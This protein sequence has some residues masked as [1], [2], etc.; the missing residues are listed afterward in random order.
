[1]VFKTI[2]L[3]ISWWK[4]FDNYHDARYVREKKLCGALRCSVVSHFFCVVQQ[5]KSGLV[6][7]IF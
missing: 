7:L 4:N 1:M 6:R 2:Q 5:P 3:C